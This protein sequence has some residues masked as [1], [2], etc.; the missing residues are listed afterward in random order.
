M[1]KMTER[2]PGEKLEEAR[3]HIRSLKWLDAVMESSVSSLMPLPK[4]LSVHRIML[5]S[6]QK[7]DEYINIRIIKIDEMLKQPNG[8]SVRFVSAAK[9]EKNH[10]ILEV[11]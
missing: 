2:Q 8:P 10:S 9:Y 1:K 4:C 7:A 3:D 5:R 6:I 11:Y